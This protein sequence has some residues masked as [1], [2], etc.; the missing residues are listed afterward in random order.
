M[1]LFLCCYSGRVS[2]I[3]NLFLYTAIQEEFARF[4]KYINQMILNLESPI[5]M[6]S[7]RNVSGEL[8][9]W[10]EA[11]PIPE[12]GVYNEKCYANITAEPK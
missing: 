11:K 5:N 3:F 12:I 8:M 2:A 6:R 4:S 7:F 10:E 9:V 1:A